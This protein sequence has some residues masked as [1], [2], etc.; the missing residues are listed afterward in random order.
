VPNL[1]RKP[2]R[3]IYLVKTEVADPWTIS[4]QSKEL[5]RWF[6]VDL[7]GMAMHKAYTIATL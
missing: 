1:K 7:V 2:E 4:S 6:G 3:S 5:A